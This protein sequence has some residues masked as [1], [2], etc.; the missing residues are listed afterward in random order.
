MTYFDSSHA[1]HHLREAKLGGR[2]IIRGVVE[3]F[4]LIN[5]LTLLFDQIR[6]SNAKERF[7]KETQAQKEGNNSEN[8]GIYW[9]DEK[10]TRRVDCSELK[11]QNDKLLEEQSY[12][13]ISSIQFFFEREGKL[14]A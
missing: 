7:S 11:K 6:I 2:N 14:F 10:E 12:P 9:I 5:L 1:E 3:I 13:S 4:P 8:T